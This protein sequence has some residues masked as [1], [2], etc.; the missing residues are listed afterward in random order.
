MEQQGWKKESGKGDRRRKGEENKGGKGTVVA[1]E[2]VVLTLVGGEK[3]VGDN[4]NA[5]KHVRNEDRS[6]GAALPG[7]DLLLL[8]LK[9]R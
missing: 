1:S 7:S 5:A 8:L 6:S 4:C 9:H 2:D 3:H